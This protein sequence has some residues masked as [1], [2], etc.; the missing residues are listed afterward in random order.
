[1]TDVNALRNLPLIPILQTFGLERDIADKSQFKS[2]RHRISIQSNSFRWYDHSARKGGG[3]SIDLVM[4]LQG[5]NFNDAC[6][7][8]NGGSTWL[9]AEAAKTK[10]IEPFKQSFVPPPNPIHLDAV[11]RYLTQERKLKPELIDW[12]IAKGLLFA[13]DFANCVFL[14]GKNGAELRGT[15]KVKFNRCYGSLDQ[16]FFIPGQQAA[17][18]VVF[19]ESAIDALSY[20][21]LFPHV[22]VFS[23]AGCQR[24]SLIKQVLQYSIQ[25]GLT[26][27]CGFDNDEEARKSYELLRAENHKIQILREVP[28]LK[29]W[30]LLC[31]K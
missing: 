25:H 30:N 9:Q 6:T 28:E 3:G 12:C 23:T 16:A 10:P 18:K 26:P 14:Y 24:Y 15:Q 31:Q 17:G 1:M 4:H 27:V 2:P 29:D 5:C 19:C 13:D 21:Q 7:W 11:R 22:P 20:R 8:L